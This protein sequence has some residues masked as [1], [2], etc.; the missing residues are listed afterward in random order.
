M[1]RFVKKLFRTLG[2]DIGRHK[3]RLTIEGFTQVLFD[4]YDINVVVDVGANVGQYAKTIRTMGYKGRIVSFEPIPASYSEL[5]KNLSRDHNW[6]GHEKA[7][8][9][10]T[11]KANMIYESDQTDMAS[12]YNASTAVP[13]MFLRWQQADKKQVTVQMDTLDNVFADCIADIVE[14]H[15][16]LKCDTQG[17]DLEVLKGGVQSLGYVQVI[18][19]EVPIVHLYKGT[20]S[21]GETIDALMEMQ[22]MPCGF[23]PVTA[24]GKDK[25]SVLEFDCI[26]IRSV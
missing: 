5:S 14:P 24:T 11:S 3:S 22:F 18:Q 16:F 10:E 15:V 9:R 1:K 4:A 6:F 17:H 25:I 19:I 8:G 7:L 20:S 23:Y 13:D 21:F 26:A 2:L 12:F